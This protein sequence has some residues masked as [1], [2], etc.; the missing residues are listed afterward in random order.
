MDDPHEQALAAGRSLRRQVPRQA[1]AVWDE[2]LRRADPLDLLEASG[3][4]RLPGLLPLRY[5]RMLR[6]PFAFMRGAA[7][8]SA[9]DVAAGPLTGIRTQ[10][11]GDCHP[12]NFGVF[13]SPE[14]RPLFDITDFDET[15]VAGWEFDVKRLVAGFVL[16]AREQAAPRPD[17]RAAAV[18]VAR[19][20]RLRLRDYALMSPVDVWYA[21]IDAEAM[22]AAA[23]AG[24]LAARVRGFLDAARTR[25]AD[26]LLRKLLAEEGNGARFRDDPPVLERLADDDETGRSFREALADYAGA[27]SPERRLLL[28]RFA[29]ADVAFKVVG[30]GSVGLRCGVSLHLSP[31]G[32]RLALQVKEARP[33]VLR[34][35]AAACPFGHDGQRVVVGQRTIQTA[36]DIFLGWCADAAGRPYYVRQLRDMNKAVPAE[37]LTDGMLVY[38][39]DLCGWSLAR[40]HARGGD[41]LR[42]S[43]YLGAGDACDRALADFAVAYADQ[44]ERD[45]ESFTKAVARGRFPAEPGR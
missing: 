43:G 26:Q 23:G 7:A 37:M 18:E 42:L 22:L 44:C 21:G 29:L 17:E 3:A 36:S 32:D 8:I 27:V 25:T 28:S 40:A 1:H 5:G 20:Y 39:A 35:H 11:C 13:A 41:A 10:A 19:S 15:A 14:R 4:G 38:F 12:A 6:S 30:V 45:F 2:S 9:A 16:L 24:R 33:S 34:D 31:A